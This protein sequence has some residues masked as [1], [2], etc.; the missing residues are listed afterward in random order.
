MSEKIGDYYF[1]HGRSGGYGKGRGNL[2][3]YSSKDGINWD[4]G[5]YLM[6]RKQTPGAVDSYSGNALVGKYDPSRPERL[7]V[8][9]DI[10][11]DGL[12]V[13]IHHWWVDILE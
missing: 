1:L 3:L 2:V 12:R 11:Y 6:S 13:N 10:S 9:A 8:Q 4:E 5:E 7:L